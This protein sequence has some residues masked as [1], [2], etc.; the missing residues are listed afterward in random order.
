MTILTLTPD[1]AGERLDSYLA[2]CI[3]AEFFFR[4]KLSLKPDNPGD[5]YDDS[6]NDDDCA[7]RFYNSFLRIYTFFSNFA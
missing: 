6:R 5:D 1:T 4:N 7:H 3:V 2:H